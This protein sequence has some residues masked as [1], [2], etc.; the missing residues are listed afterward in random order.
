MNRIEVLQELKR[1]YSAELAEDK[2]D[3]TNFDCAV[4]DALDSLIA[5][6]QSVQRTATKPRK[7][8]LTHHDDEIAKSG[9]V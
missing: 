3:G 9:A 2:Q 5:A 1:Y 6:Q 7:Y 8:Y 4:L